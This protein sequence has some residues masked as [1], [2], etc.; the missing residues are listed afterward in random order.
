MSFELSTQGGGGM[1]IKK[2]KSVSKTIVRRRN[3]R[4]TLWVD[5]SQLLVQGE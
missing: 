3:D 2:W 1:K 5:A 4:T